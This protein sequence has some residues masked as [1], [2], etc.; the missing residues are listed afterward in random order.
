M[1][2]AGPARREPPKFKLPT[3]AKSS[4][5][6]TKISVF[7]NGDFFN[8]P[9]PLVVDRKVLSL[10][11]LLERATTL[12]PSRGALR[13]L[14]HTSG[15]RVHDIAEVEDGEG[16]VVAAMERFKKVPYTTVTFRDKLMADRQRRQKKGF[17]PPASLERQHRK[18]QAKIRGRLNDIMQAAANTNHTQTRVVYFVKN[19]ETRAEYCQLIL[20]PRN[21]QSMDQVLQRLGFRMGVSVALRCAYT[22]AGRQIVGVGEFEHGATYVATAGESF[23]SIPYTPK[24][25][26][27]RKLPPL[28]VPAAVSPAASSSQ[29]GGSRKRSRGKG[30]GSAAEGSDTE[31]TATTMDSHEGSS[32]SRHTISVTDDESRPDSAPTGE[33]HRAPDANSS[34]ETT[35]EGSEAKADQRDP[36][37]TTHD[38]GEGNSDKEWRQA[39]G[40]LLELLTGKDYRKV[41]KQLCTLDDSG[42]ERCPLAKLLETAATVSSLLGSEAP[43]VTA[44]AETAADWAY[45][46]VHK[47]LESSESI[48]RREAKILLMLLLYIMWVAETLQLSLPPAPEAS[49]TEAE[50]AALEGL[51]SSLVVSV[52]ERRSLP[53]GTIPLET[54]VTYYTKARCPDIFH[55]KKKGA[56]AEGEAAAAE[57]PAAPE[58]EVLPRRHRGSSDE[59]GDPTLNTLEDTLFAMIADPDKLGLFWDNADPKGAG[60]A[61]LSVVNELVIHSH[62]LLDNPVALDHAWKLLSADSESSSDSH[63]GDGGERW[64]VKE[65]LTSLL[66]NLFY[67]TKLRRVCK[68]GDDPAVNLNLEEFEQHCFKLNLHM[69][70]WD[71]QS[72]FQRI[73]VDDTVPIAVFERWYTTKQQQIVAAMGG[74]PPKPKKSKSPSKG[75]KKRSTRVSKPAAATETDKPSKA[76]TDATPNF[77]SS[78]FDDL[79][80]NLL[81]LALDTEALERL[82][83]E[84]D[85]NGNDKV[86]LAEIDKRVVA[87]YPLLNNKPALMRAYQ[88]TTLKDGDGDAWVEPKEFPQLLVNLFYFNKL[89]Q[90]F[91]VIDKDD[92]RRL[93]LAEFKASLADL[94]MSLSYSETETEFNAMDANGGGVVLFDEFC[95]WFT[96][97]HDPG[98][99][100][101]TSAEVLKRRREQRKQPGSSPTNPKRGSRASRASPTKSKRGS[102]LSRVTPIKRGSRSSQ[103]SPDKRP[104]EPKRA[105]MTRTPPGSPAPPRASKTGTAKGGPTGSE[106]EATQTA[107]AT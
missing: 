24:P 83:D 48:G 71:G 51:E 41:W 47:T 42:R 61:E 91:D 58:Q 7:V 77:D 72:E 38:E 19:G 105:P 11:I 23:R 106:R 5:R 87:K 10:D 95:V 81:S 92:D 68:L 107:T 15:Q 2:M 44:T 85:V 39:E 25:L 1:A 66:L 22:L 37:P 54:F 59:Y 63:S 57:A 52:L 45:R 55:K 32:V 43:G 13:R 76:P 60:K 96:K 4:Q 86:S 75:G 30:R 99:D 35:G 18:R 64:V 29:D 89:F 12:F 104:S 79:E 74:E 56:E 8:P 78:K 97:K 34:D 70:E 67:L 14:Y 98:R 53:D 73:K 36:T 49:L 17:A 94:G 100:I 46:S 101:V 82:W 88:Q 9:K 62:P 20:N 69:S 6:A 84:I 102:I 50:V 28:H 33:S 65:Q 3:I 31:A 16:Y 21:S 26:R 40:V 27:T 93:N 80:R 103:A 90:C